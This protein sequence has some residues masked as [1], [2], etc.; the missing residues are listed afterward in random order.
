MIEGTFSVKFR[1]KWAKKTSVKRQ[2]V[3]SE[4]AGQNG[5]QAQRNKWEKGAD[6]LIMLETK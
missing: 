5:T 3:Q 6:V 4:G 2:S 1:D